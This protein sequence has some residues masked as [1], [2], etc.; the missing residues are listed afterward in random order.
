MSVI[1]SSNSQA[2]YP[3]PAVGW[4]ATIMLAFLYWLSVLDRYVISLLVDPIKRDLGLTDVQFGIL[5]GLAFALTFVIFGLVFGALADRVNRRKL[6]YIGVTIWSIGTAFCGVAQNFTHL[7]LARVGVGAGEAALQPSATSMISDLFPREK[8]TSAMAVY[9]IGSTVGNGTALIIGGAIVDLVFNMGAITLPILGSIRPWQIVFF[10]VGIPGALL[11]LCIFTVPEP[12]RRGQRI[13]NDAG[14]AWYASYLDLL[15]FMKSKRRF[16]ACH[17]AGFTLASAVIAGNAAWLPAYMSRSFNWSAGRVGLVLGM[18]VM[19]G[20]IAGKLLCGTLVDALYRRGYH[21]A[22]LRWYSLC[23]LI[24]TPIGI[25][26]C[27]RS[28]PYVFLAGL[29]VFQI[30]ISAM[31]ACAFASLNLVTPNELRGTGIAI[32]TTV[33][34]LIGGGAGSILIAVISE[35]VFG[36]NASLGLGM[37]TLIGVCCPIAAVLLFAG[38]R[39]MRAAMLEV[40]TAATSA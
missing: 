2:S 23:L 25:F 9:S 29:G 18:T 22:Q 36:G 4:Y 5:H 17:Y 30:L 24:A 14:R 15:K 20:S 8:L 33:F 10:I 1:A 12:V 40:E 19:A 26:A 34:G 7:L 28:D 35:R 32:F 31:P 21:D 11:A 13:T 38:M 39:A 16:F 3:A 37:A 27:T 6:I